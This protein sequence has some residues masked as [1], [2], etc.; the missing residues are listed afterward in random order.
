MT[1]WKLVSLLQEDPEKGIAEVLDL[2]GGAIKVICANILR[3]CSREDVEEAIS[4]TMVAIWKSANH[5]EQTRGASFKS[6][7]YGIARKTALAK[8][9]STG[10]DWNMI[11]LE[12]DQIDERAAIEEQLGKREEEKLL[13]EVVSELGEPDRTIFILRYFYFFRVKEIAEKLRLTDKKV[14]NCLCRGRK[15]LKERLV[16]KGVERV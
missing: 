15:R 14:E 12:E 8:R 4:D 16:Q 2:Y 9:K 5:F 1:E 7:C 10:K 11:P 13:H 6:Y 3:D